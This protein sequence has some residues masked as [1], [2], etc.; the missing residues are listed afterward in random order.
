[1]IMKLLQ[2]DNWLLIIMLLEIIK[3]QVV[4][5]NIDEIEIKLDDINPDKDLL[6]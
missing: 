1:M 6:G 3:N 2:Q 5:F 4:S